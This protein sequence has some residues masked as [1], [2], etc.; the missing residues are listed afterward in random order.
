MSFENRAALSEFYHIS[1]ISFYSYCSFFAILFDV[2][3]Y[4]FL[5]ENN[6]WLYWILKLV[7]CH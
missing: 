1:L 2:F 6:P 5:R 4:S 7:S 3:K